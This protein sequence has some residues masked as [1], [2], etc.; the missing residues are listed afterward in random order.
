MPMFVMSLVVMLCSAEP[1]RTEAQKLKIVADFQSLN[2]RE[3]HVEP[4][5]QGAHQVARASRIAEVGGASPK[6]P[7][8]QTARAFID[9]NRHFFGLKPDQV[10]PVPQLTPLKDGKTY[11]TFQFTAAALVSPPR[12]RRAA[13]DSL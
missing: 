6:R 2:G 7:P 5:W 4:V 11:V 9:K 3:W 12:R 8:T 10:L 13:R 1:E